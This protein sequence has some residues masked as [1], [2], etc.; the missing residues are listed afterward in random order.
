MTY[1]LTLAEVAEEL[2]VSPTHVR[3]LIATHGLPH[4]RIGERR[5]IVRRV[6]LEAW[7]ETRVVKEEV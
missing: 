7:L 1:A 3:R 6:D 4:I 2:R 5:I